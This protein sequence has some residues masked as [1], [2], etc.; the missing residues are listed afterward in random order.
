MQTPD[1]K[2]EGGEIA[3]A[4]GCL[5]NMERI[6]SVGLPTQGTLS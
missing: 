2:K 3:Y 5:E 6:E 1:R 4:A